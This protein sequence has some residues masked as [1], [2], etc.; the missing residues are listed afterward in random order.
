MAQLNRFF[1][2]QM[3]HA[4]FTPPIKFYRN[5]GVSF[6]EWKGTIT[7]IPTYQYCLL[8]KR[9]KKFFHFICIAYQ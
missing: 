5:L 7:N 4:L 1:K 9:N 2:V 6:L 8:I 3:L